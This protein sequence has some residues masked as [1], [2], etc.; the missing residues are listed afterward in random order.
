MHDDTEMIESECVTNQAIVQDHNQQIVSLNDSPRSRMITPPSP[1]FLRDLHEHQQQISSLNSNLHTNSMEM[2]CRGNDASG[3]TDEDTQVGSEY[4]GNLNHVDI[5]VSQGGH[6]PSSSA[7][8]PVGDV[9]DSYYQPTSA[10]AGYAS[11]AQELSIGNPHF[12]QEQAVQLLDLETDRQDKKDILHRQTEDM[13]FFSSYPNQD[14]NEVFH[15][16]FKGQSNVAY[17]QQQK[18]LG[19][20][21]Q[22]GNNHSLMMES[23]GQ[24]SGHFREQVQVHPSLPL[25]MRQKSLNDIYV[26]QNIHESM[27]SGGGRFMPTRQ[28]ELAVNVHDWA[29]VNNNSVRMLVPPSQPPQMSWYAAASENGA[30]DGGWPSSLVG[31]NHNLSLSRGGNSDQTLFSVLTECNEML[32]PPTRPNYDERF[33]QA[34]NYSGGIPSS[35]SS[36]NNFLQQTPNY[37]NGH[38]AA[39]GAG[40][41]K[42]NNL[43]WMGVSHHNS[44]LQ[45]SIAKPFLRSW[46]Q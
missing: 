6:L 27:Y 45:D 22:P 25:D 39:A 18:Q 21:F 43:G 31:V 37:L 16:F 40:I 2:E 46:N 1:G 24:F 33:I 8:W 38:E 44:G 19:L 35:S 3:T 32:P 29:A 20:E 12:I 5:T 34:G 17:H 9:H 28:D 11:A 41:N 36:S 4:P 30:R 15:H 10:N 23:A 7:I 42:M 26:H 14:R 13:S